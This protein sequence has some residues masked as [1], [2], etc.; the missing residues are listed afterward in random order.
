MGLGERHTV[1][2]STHILSE[3]EATCS[4]VIVISKGRLVAKGALEDIRNQAVGDEL[5]MVVRGDADKV[6]ALLESD[7]QVSVLRSSAGADETLRLT[8]R[9]RGDDASLITERLVSSLV[10]AGLRIREVMS[11]QASL[12]QV[13]SQLTERA[14]EAKGDDNQQE[15]A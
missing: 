8:L 5:V 10:G 4:R 2:L 15:P 3:V 9:L 11:A 6:K 7:E 1:L 13:F 12:E 14:H